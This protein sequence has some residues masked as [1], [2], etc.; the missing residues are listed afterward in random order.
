MKLKA[1][2]YASSCFTIERYREAYVLNIK[3]L[4]TQ[5]DWEQSDLGFNVLPLILVRPVGR[6][7]K[8]RIRGA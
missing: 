6:L 5:E 7:R 1:K 3:P 2:D 4:P 8:K